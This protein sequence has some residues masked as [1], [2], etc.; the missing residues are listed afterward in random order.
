[1][2]SKNFANAQDL[3]SVKE[4][5]GNTVVLKDG[6]LRQILMVGGMNFSLK[7]DAEQD[8]ITQAYQNFLNGIDFPL[9]IIIHSRKINIEKYLDS[10]RA[11]E[12]HGESSLLHNQMEEYREFIRGFVAKNPIMEK[13]FLVV[14]PFFPLSISAVG[15]TSAL[16]KYLPFFKKNK[17]AEEK[18]KEEAEAHFNESLTQLKQRVSQVMEGIFSVGSEAV[19]LGN[20]QLVE[21]FYNFYNPESIERENI[22]VPKQD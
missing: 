12:D 14:V 9:Q 13:T 11:Y 22:N 8:L 19:V 15:S 10:L 4:I 1:M 6:S 17:E 21:L 16:S 5:R 20:E 18:A 2:P 7:S 3:V